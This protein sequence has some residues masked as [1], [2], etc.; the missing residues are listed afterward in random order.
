MRILAI[1][2]VAAVAATVP[3]AGPALA[4]SLVET[5]RVNN[6]PVT[7]DLAAG[8]TTPDKKCGDEGEKPCLTVDRAIVHALLMCNGPP[9]CPKQSPDGEAKYRHSKL[10]ERVEADP[11]NVALAPD[12]IT[13]IENLI[14]E[15]YSPVVVRAVWDKLGPPSSVAPK[16]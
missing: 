10:A 9:L 14:G 5:V 12:E 1:A 11:I 15:M 8:K 13:T 16:K 7:D 3:A 4:V 6:I 2:F